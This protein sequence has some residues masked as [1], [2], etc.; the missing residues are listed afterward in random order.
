MKTSTIL[1]P[2]HSSFLIIGETPLMAKTNYKNG[3]HNFF[4]FINRSKLINRWSLMFNRKSESVAEH[5]HQTAIIAHSLGVIDNVIFKLNTNADRCAV[6]ALYHDAS[7]VFTGDM[8]TPVKYRNSSMITAYT[9]ATAAAEQQLLD[10][11]PLQLQPFY[12]SYISCNNDNSREAT[13]A[14]Y[15]DKISALV[16]CIEEVASGNNEFLNAKKTTQTTIE[17]LN[18]KTVNYFI[19]NFLQAFSKNLDELIGE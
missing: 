4:A 18:D 9:E 10:S 14:H 17:N 5:S 19:D 11:L 1:Q 13:L 16:K 6:Y 3:D 15:A 8:P 12:S 2:P 7:E